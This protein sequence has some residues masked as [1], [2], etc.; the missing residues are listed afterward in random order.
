MAEPSPFDPPPQCQVSIVPTTIP[1]SGL[2]RA[3]C[4]TARPADALAVGL[5]PWSGLNCWGNDIDIHSG[6]TRYTR[7]L[8]WTP[9]TR[10]VHDSSLT[11]A[12]PPEDL[13]G[14]SADW[15]P[16]VTLSP[17]LRHSPH[18]RFDGAIHQYRE[19]EIAGSSE[20]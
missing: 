6:R 18:Y 1:A 14:R 17:G 5:F 2:A 11:G 9:V 8:F 15:H 20:T 10:S 13:V 3:R 16:V 12:L 7:Y 19:L 4:H